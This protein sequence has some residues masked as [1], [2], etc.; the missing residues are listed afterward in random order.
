VGRGAVADPTSASGVKT[1]ERGGSLEAEQR[2][3]G[4]PVL[5]CFLRRWR[6]GSKPD[7]EEWLLPPSPAPIVIMMRRAPPHLAVVL[8]WNHPGMSDLSTPPRPRIGI[9]Y[10]AAPGNGASRWKES[11]PASPRANSARVCGPCMKNIYTACINPI[12]S[13][14]GAGGHVNFLA[15]RWAWSWKSRWHGN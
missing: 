13:P 15:W 10:D 9:C 12:K 11:I 8:Q 7:R 5:P 3:E 4:C 6:I 1:L 14:I 2:T